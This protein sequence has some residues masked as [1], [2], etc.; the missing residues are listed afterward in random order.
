[1]RRMREYKNPASAE[2]RFRGRE[3]FLL[4]V[5]FWEGMGG[6]EMGDGMGTVEIEG[7][8]KR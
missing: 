1:M 5:F 7:E 6:W 2:S 4:R 3:S 8:G